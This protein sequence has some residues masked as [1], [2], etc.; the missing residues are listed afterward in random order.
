MLGLV[1]VG[2]C[3]EHVCVGERVLSRMC[4]RVWARGCVSGCVCGYV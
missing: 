4:V 3:V 2:A 1:F